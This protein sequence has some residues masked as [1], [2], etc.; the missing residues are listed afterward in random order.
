MYKRIN[1]DERDLIALWHSSGVSNKEIAKRLGRLVSTIGREIKRNL[2]EN[3]HYVAIS[4]QAK[5]DKRKVVS[6]ARHPLKNKRIFAYVVR[7][8]RFGWSPDV[9]SGRLK[10][11][12]WKRCHSF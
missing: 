4:A 2:A 5:V 11:K 12:V 10:L 8:L 3:G 1:S 6:R 7:K 9:I